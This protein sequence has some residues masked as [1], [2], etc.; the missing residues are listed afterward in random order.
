MVQNFHKTMIVYAIILFEI[1]FLIGM[2]AA[3]VMAGMMSVE[4]SNAIFYSVGA[5]I[6]VAMLIR[7]KLDSRNL[8]GV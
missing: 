5:I 1:G 8:K 3:F 7:D 6:V 2:N 4:M